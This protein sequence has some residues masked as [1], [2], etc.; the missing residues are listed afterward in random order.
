MVCLRRMTW[1]VHG[2]DLALEDRVYLEDGRNG[3]QDG[4]R[5]DRALAGID[6]L[7]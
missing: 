3:W 1:P 4:S 7:R 2:L 6:L 5:Y